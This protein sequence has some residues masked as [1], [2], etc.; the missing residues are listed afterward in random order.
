M[1]PGTLSNLLRVLHIVTA[2]LMA[3]PYY[4]LAAVN[5]RA[6]LGPPLGDRTDRYMENILKNRTTAC[7]IFQITILLGG[8]ALIA[9]RVN[10]GVNDLNWWLS[11]KAIIAKIV[12]LLL[13]VASLSW[14]RWVM[15]PQIDE[16]FGD[17]GELSDEKKQRIMA[18][19]TRRK[20]MSS[21]CMFMAFTAAMLGTQV[22]FKFPY[23]ITGALVA[24]IAL[25]AWRSYKS[26]TKFGWI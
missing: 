26:T 22:A 6:A 4:A 16:L 5:Q 23:W 12:I 18:L 20:R 13:M 9:S 2:M 17:Y 21:F 3:W 8:F 24:A 11:N 7:F 15:Q 1:D 19:R 10:D 14:V 25:W